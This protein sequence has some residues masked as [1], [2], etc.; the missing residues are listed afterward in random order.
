MPEQLSLL[1]ASVD[2]R[3]EIRKFTDSG[4]QEAISKALNNIPKDKKIA[5]IAEAGMTSAR[6]FVAYRIG[7][8]FSIVG[9]LEKKYNTKG[10]SGEIAIVWQK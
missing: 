3:G 5:V 2:T 7:N 1:G 9:A 10:V 6:G 4:I 8:E